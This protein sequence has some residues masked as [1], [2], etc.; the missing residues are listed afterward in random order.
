MCPKSSPQPSPNNQPQET[1]KNPW[2]TPKNI[3]SILLGILP[4]LLLTSKLSHPVRKFCWSTSLLSPLSFQLET[5]KTYQAT[6]PKEKVC[7]K[8]YAKWCLQDLKNPYLIIPE[9]FFRS[10]LF[11]IFRSYKTLYAVRLDELPQPT[12]NL[13]ALTRHPFEG[14]DFP[15]PKPAGATLDARKS[16]DLVPDICVSHMG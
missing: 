7:C 13:T 4:H 10:S 6:V 5:P 16:S 15:S 2:K 3:N 14:G 12:G 8:N 1:K 9:F 11:N